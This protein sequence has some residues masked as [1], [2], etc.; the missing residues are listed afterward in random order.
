MG[1]ERWTEYDRIDEAMDLVEQDWFE[2]RLT[3]NPLAYARADED[4]KAVAAWVLNFLTC[5]YTNSSALAAKLK[6]RRARSLFRKRHDADM[7]RLEKEEKAWKAA[8]ALLE[9]CIVLLRDWY[10]DEDLSLGALFALVS[11]AETSDGEWAS[12]LDF[13][14]NQIKTGKRY[15]EAS[16][17]NDGA[18]EWRWV[19]TKL[20]RKGDGAAPGETGG[21][22]PGEDTALGLYE[23]FKGSTMPV[24][25]EAVR[26]CRTALWHMAEHVGSQ[27]A[28]LAG[29]AVGEAPRTCS[30][31]GGLA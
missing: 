17:G 19:P 8:M 22:S 30:D 12:P 31:K 1:T 15:A 4:A 26:M 20:E 18:D 9:A 23:S 29:K 6:K 3:F 11:I 14:F 21:L 28:L 25:Y 5:P 24:Q 13:L 10:P 16:G 2:K 27:L 7:A